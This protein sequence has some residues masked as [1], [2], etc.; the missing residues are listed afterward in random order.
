MA[1]D[2]VLL[3]AAGNGISSLRFYQW[4]APTVS[5]GHFQGLGEAAIPPRFH[6]LEIVRRLSGGG[7]ILHHLELTYSCALPADHPC[8]REPGSIYD[9][10]HAAIIDVFSQRGVSAQLRGDGAFPEKP[11]LCFS[12][13]DGRDIVIGR[14]KI[15]GSAQR[16]RRGAVLQHGS[17]LLGQS[18]WAPEF[19]GIYELTGK[20]LPVPELSGELAAAIGRHLNWDL[21][22]GELDVAEAEQAS[23]C[24]WQYMI[25]M[26]T[27]RH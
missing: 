11:F 23:R 25:P 15:V 13:G 21:V 1:V 7:A 18:P 20:Q 10:V 22:P 16:R 6:Q 8:T 27:S 19:P 5:L 2:E 9:H 26:P 3:D 17:L 24:A 14:N 4:S 12:R